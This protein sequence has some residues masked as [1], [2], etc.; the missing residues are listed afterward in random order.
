MIPK[1]RRVVSFL[2]V[3]IIGFELTARDMRIRASAV[4]RDELHIF[5]SVQFR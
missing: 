1:R 2:V 5:V 4:A 3:W